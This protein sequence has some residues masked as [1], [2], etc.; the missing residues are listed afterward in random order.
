M[1]A[2]FFRSCG[3]FRRFSGVLGESC[4]AKTENFSQ[5]GAG[6][7]KECA[8]RCFRRKLAIGCVLMYGGAVKSGCPFVKIPVAEPI[9]KTPGQPVRRVTAVKESSD[10]PLQQ[11]QR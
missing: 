4:R 10:Y 2:V 7:R 3:I 1:R 6:Y 9:G 8:K 5:I 11:R